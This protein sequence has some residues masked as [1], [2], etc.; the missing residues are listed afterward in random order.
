MRAEL[1]MGLGFRRDLGAPDVQHFLK[2]EQR[3]GNG[4]RP[5]TRSDRCS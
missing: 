1:C 5:L 3:G 4:F 2:L